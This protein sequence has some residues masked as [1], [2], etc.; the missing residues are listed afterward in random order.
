MKRKKDM[1]RNKGEDKTSER[2][3]NKVEIGILPEKEF[4]IMIVK[5][6]QDLGEIMEKRQEMFSKYLELKNKQ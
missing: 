6:M 3:L 4:I 5:M 2:Q 1:S